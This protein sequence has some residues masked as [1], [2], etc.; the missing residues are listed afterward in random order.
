MEDYIEGDLELLGATAVEDKLQVGVPETLLDLQRAG[1]KIWMLT[2]DKL[3]TAQNIGYLSNLLSKNSKIY[4]LS[5]DSKAD[6][7]KGLEN[8]N[9]KLHK[10]K[11]NQQQV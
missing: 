5:A 7:L 6:T 8:I 3:E 10:T 9:R 1:I 2:G 11:K 4:V